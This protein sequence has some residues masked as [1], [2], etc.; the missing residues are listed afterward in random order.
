[1]QKRRARYIGYGWNVEEFSFM[2]DLVRILKELVKYG[3]SLF[4]MILIPM[5]KRTLKV[6]EF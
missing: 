2:D 5:I 1:M 3:E 4:I 6:Q